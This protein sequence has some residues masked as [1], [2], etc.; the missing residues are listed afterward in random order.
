[1]DFQFAG[2]SFTRY[3]HS[4]RQTGTLPAFAPGWTHTFSDRIL[5]GGVYNMKTIRSDGYAEYFVSLGNN[6]YKS[7]QTSRKKLVEFLDGTYKIY[8]ET[9][10][11]QS[12]NTAGRLVRQEQSVAGL[13]TIDFTYNGEQ[14]VRAQDQTGRALILN[15]VDNRLDNIQLPDG[16]LVQ[17]Q[18]DGLGNFTQ[19][20]Y[21]DGT[22]KQYHYNEAGLSLAN[23]PHA[24]TGITTENGLRYSSYGY[25]ANGR[26]NLSERHKGDGTF[27]E[28]TTINYTN[29][30]QPVVTLPH[31]EVVT[32][33][34]TDEGPYRRITSVA[35]GSGN[36][37]S[38][39]TGGSIG[40]TT[41]TLGV[42]T[43]YTYA[44]DYLST[45]FEAFG[46]PEERK[47][48]TTRDA[49]YRTTSHD[50]QAKSGSTYVTKQQQSFT[51]NSRAQVLTQTTTDPA[52]SISRTTTTTYCEQADIDAATC[53]FIGLIKTMDGARTDVADTMTY[54]YRQTDEAS[55]A[56]SPST[57]PYRKGQLWKVTNALGQVSETLSYD[58]AGR[59]LSVKDPN[60]VITDFE[61]DARGRMT[62]R[63]LRGANNAADTDDQI[64]RIEYW[65]T[66][67]VKKV[68]QSDGAFTAYAYDDA[69]RLTGIT[70]NAGNSIAYT[71]NAAS[72]RTKEDTKDSTGALQRTLSRTYNTLGQL[73]AVTDAYGRSTGF[74]YDANSNLD[75]TTDALTRVAD[76]N[77]DPLDRL[78]RTLQDVN[79]I[80]AETKFSYDTLDNLTQVNDPKALNTTYTYNGFSDLTQLV[81]PDTGTTL[82]TYDSAGNRKTQKDARNKTTTYNYDA[83]NRLT[84]ATYAATA[85][86]TTY[87]YDTAQT[88]CVAGE[89]FTVGRLTKITDQSGNTVYCY[90][91]F[92]NLVRKEQTSNAKVFTLRYTWNVAGQLT[93]VIYPDGA[94]ADYL[95]DAQGRVLEVGAKTA[96]GTRQVLLTNASYYPF[97]PVAQ[98]SY[99]NGRLMK[100]SLNQNYQPG[101]VEVTTAGGISLG[102]E[103]DAVGNL[104]TLRNANQADP[105][106]RVFGYDA[107]NRITESK[108]GITNA[109]LEGYTYDK[110]GNRTSATVGATTTPYAYLTGNH[111]LNTVGTAAARVYDANGNS[112]S[113]PGTV[114]KNFVYGDHNR[115]T[116][117][118]EGTTVK[119]NYVYN[120]R[121]EQVRKYA[122]STTNVYSLYDEAGHWLG[123][124]NNAAA[125]TQQV[126]WFGDL[127]VGVLVGAGAA[128][129]L[130]YIEADALGTPRVV[131]DPTRGTQGTAVWT[132][133]LAG[134]A[135]GVTAPNQNPDGDANQFVFNMRFPGQRFDAVTGLNYNYFRD[136]DPSTGRY[137]QSDPIGLNGGISTYGYA[138][139]NPM[140]RIDPLGLYCFSEA[141]IRGISGLISGG[142]AGAYVG[143]AGGPGAAAIF[144]VLGAVVGGGLGYL[145]GYHADNQ[146]RDSAMNSLT[147]GAVSAVVGAY[148]GTRPAIGGGVAGGLVGAAV[149]GSFDNRAAGLIIGNAAG[150][151]FGS[152]ITTFFSMNKGVFMSAAKGGG[153]GAVAGL[154]QYGIEELLRR[155]NDCDEDCEK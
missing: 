71:L 122:T 69:H 143:G 49:N 75:T 36:F 6:Q 25:A 145:D 115:M 126:I 73:Q 96:T 23:N 28:K 144:G 116:Q 31:G 50:V 139:G 155:G 12:F 20:T 80:A 90:D 58:G 78:S 29:I 132:W 119:M 147:G 87:I 103:F 14:L 17:Y 113:I 84:S 129:K 70:D 121:G 107:L 131:V 19:A 68:T 154:I 76:N 95:Y 110:T 149:G 65:P 88:A 30:S 74:T 7:S 98:W 44:A 22:S 2:E 142:L 27:V 109:V 40:Q 148:P 55:C 59:V 85:L 97:G 53:P 86:N 35:G 91:R 57:C 43:K 82:Y 16:I 66:G 24:L 101:F 100:R 118:K 38:N 123:D 83:L 133:D 93:S 52:T 42:I 10:R 34:L 48:V 135:F 64:T 111:R 136:Y 37:L 54:T 1:M 18:F 89:T 138:D 67:L 140:A 130:H 11:I 39:Y 77:Y 15:Y 26:V 124:Y 46:T 120:G 137:S 112:T 33:G 104:K 102:Y 13:Y 60:G 128:Q 79:G 56:T 5:D 117:Y 51:Y 108:D 47:F 8:D 41:S 45:R 4:L 32:Y 105:P 146:M 150:S 81:S 127:P 62:A 114:V 21:P 141:E 153:I 99:G 9:G 125:A 106:R 61:Y 94:I 92:G 3:Y 134:E 152:A 63:K 72:E 151:S